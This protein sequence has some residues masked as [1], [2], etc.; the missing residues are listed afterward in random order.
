[1]RLKHSKVKRGGV[2]AN[3]WYGETDVITAEALSTGLKIRFHLPS[4]G[5]GETDV[6]VTLGEEDL[7]LLF[8]ELAS[9][10]PELADTFAESAHMAVL[11]LKASR[12]DR[13]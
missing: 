7:R 4:K 1:M 10:I 11:S 3:Y 2:T 9:S 13:G 6:Q 5:G 8:K 12:T